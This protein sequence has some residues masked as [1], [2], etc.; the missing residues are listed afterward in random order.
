M[1]LAKLNGAALSLKENYAQ[2]MAV[3]APLGS[4]VST[5][6]VAVAYAGGDV[7]VATLLALFASALWVYTLTIYS[8]KL[9]SP[10]GYYTFVYAAYRSKPIAFAEA[11]IELFSFVLLNAVN[12]IAVYLMTA[13][14]LRYY[15]LSDLSPYLL[16]AVLLIGILYP[17]LVSF[18]TNIRRLLSTVVMVVATLEVLVLIALFALSLREG[19]RTEL[20]LPPFEARLGDI[21][22]AF[23]VIMVS[24]DGVGTATYLGEETKSPT[25]NVTKGMWLAFLLGGLS[26]VL[27]TYAMIALWPYG[28]AALSSSEQP[29]IEL[30]SQYGSLPALLVF[31]IATK[32]LL[33]SNVGT[34]LAA[35]RIFFNLARENAAPEIL[36]STN[37]HGQPHVA[38]LLVGL[39]T[40][41]ITL[42]FG[43]LLGYAEAFV[44]LGV[45]TGILW[46]L[47][48]VLSS[49]GAPLLLLRLQPSATLLIAR[50]SV[51]PI[52]STLLNVG[53]LLMSVM[54][55]TVVSTAAL[56]GIAL[57]GALWY[58]LIGRY[59]IPGE[60]VVDESNNVMKLDDYLSSLR[61]E[62]GH[63]V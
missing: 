58:V 21:A 7:V 50:E 42:A 12:V 59:G 6:T 36:Q 10:G 41:L 30:V 18:T 51:A 4:V 33:I 47:G 2:A 44:N 60:L 40:A 19:L 28:I 25:N 34:T 3:T 16:P 23:M 13:T 32:S 61:A 54:D 29:L 1:G 57:L 49:A 9:A 20:V 15:G 24:L 48:R 55:L 45:A 62:R 35:A 14:L 17:T 31:L 43:E 22:L 63:S 39:L 52:A 56:G 8:R 46:I 53:G 37:V 27:G 26:M 5:T 38:T 11:I